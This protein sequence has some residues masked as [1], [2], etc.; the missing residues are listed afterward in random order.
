MF[1]EYDL[2]Q[3]TSNSPPLA[4]R[5]NAHASVK[6]VVIVVAA[7]LRLP[8]RD[9]EAATRSSPRIARGRQ[10]AMYLAHV[11]TG[12]SMSAVGRAFGRDRTTVAHACR[13]VEERREDPCFDAMAGCLERLIIAIAD[14]VHW[15]GR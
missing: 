6:A 8:V 14:V 4:T 15:S 3:Q 1:T 13:V 12:L 5:R 11:G 9:I 10:L 2:H 7:V